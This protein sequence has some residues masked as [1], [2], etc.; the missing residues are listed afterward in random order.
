MDN[1]HSISQT[2][3]DRS[4]YT[5]NPDIQRVK[6]WLDLTMLQNNQLGLSPT[7]TA[8]ESAGADFLGTT[9]NWEDYLINNGV[10]S[11][12]IAS[13]S[14]PITPCYSGA[15]GP[16][17]FDRGHNPTYKS[18]NSIKWPRSSL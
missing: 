18:K 4:Y 15:A 7:N 11:G 16:Y 9:G 10:T 13:G 5:G 1:N 2:N 6:V 12:G 17:L 8:M 14:T 3:L